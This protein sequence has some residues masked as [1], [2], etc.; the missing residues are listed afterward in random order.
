VS[1][2]TSVVAIDG[3][4]VRLA[5]G[6]ALDATSVVVAVEGP[7]ASRLLGLP[8]VGSRP[9]ACVYFDAP[10]A[11]TPTKYVMLN[12]DGMGPALNVAV[13]SNVAPSY[14]P[15]GRH[16]VAAAVPAPPTTTELDVDVRTQLRSWW[17]PQVDQ[18]RH[19]RTYRIEHGQPDQSP[20]F[21]P[22]RAVSLGGG[23]FVCGD[24]RDTGSIQGAMYS[25]RRCA[26][27]VLSASA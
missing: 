21:H 5:D 16:L 17:G 19:L 18:W 10:T 1:L 24:H 13:M 22:K 11:P 12:G 15:A 25:G 26:E 27:A 2:D 20:P 9:V 14:A 6:T 3:T 7:A 23:V 8:P 4:T